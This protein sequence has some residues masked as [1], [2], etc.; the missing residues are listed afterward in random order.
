VTD[1]DELRATVAASC[2]VLAMQGLVREITGH[3]SVRVP[4]TDDQMLIRCR[5][6][7][8]QGLPFTAAD[9]VQLVDLDGRGAQPGYQV[10]LE[11]PIHGELLR[12][13]PE[14]NCVIHAHPPASL[15]CGILDLQLRPILGSFDPE[16]MRLAY[17]GVPV[18]PRSVLIRTAALAVQLAEVM[19]ERSVCLMRG[20]GI[21]V[22]GASVE[23]ATVR[24]IRLETLAEITLSAAQTGR[25]PPDLDRADIEDFVGPPGAPVPPA[26]TRGSEW[27]WKHYLRMLAVRDGQL[28]HTG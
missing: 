24:A 10:P 5:P 23:E 8:E 9:C 22:V 21:T 4:G 7:N 12:R 14:V 6:D 19:G 25:T 17:E 1:L 11:R 2:R 27:V 15:L 18:Y 16:A 28:G 13:R 3:V 20:H 26:L